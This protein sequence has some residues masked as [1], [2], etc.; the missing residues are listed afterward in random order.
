MTEEVK[1]TGPNMEPVRGLSR[2]RS[3]LNAALDS[4]LTMFSLGWGFCEMMR[5]G[6][7][8]R[9]YVD[10]YSCV[11]QDAITP[12]F[13]TVMHPSQIIGVSFSTLCVT[14]LS[15]YNVCIF[16]PPK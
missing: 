2:D 11:W 5:P 13:A 7:G 6:R 9:C 14:F 1:G 16:K 12:Q 3:F 8:D 4:E 10:L 15:K